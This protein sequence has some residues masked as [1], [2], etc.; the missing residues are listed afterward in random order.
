MHV[1]TALDDLDFTHAGMVPDPLSAAYRPREERDP[2]LAR[3]SITWGASEL[4]GLLVAY[5]I[6][7]RDA[8]LPRWVL[9]QASHYKAL[10]LPKVIAWKA[11]LRARSTKSKAADKGKEREQ[12][13]LRTWTAKHS[14]RFVEPITVQH[15]SM[16]PV[17]WF[18]LVDRHC[19][20]LSGTPD[21]WAR[22][23]DGKHVVIELKCT[24]DPGSRIRW[25]HWIQT[26]ALIGIMSAGSGLNVVGEQWVNDRADDLPPRTFVVDADESA[27]A[28]SRSVARHAMTL[29]EKLR[30]VTDVN[31]CAA[32]WEESLREARDMRDAATKE[33]E[34]TLDAIADLEEILARQM[35]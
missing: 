14:A 20:Q 9:D 3:R 26:Q 25:H 17:E 4:P 13:L 1:V 21:A 30:N 27:I 31:V 11:G 2:W 5:D 10:R 35:T 22:S 15:A 6:A 7:P 8:G 33:V 19:P 34:E 18:P 12:E 23:R 28:L 29:V 24:Y 16:A 32:L